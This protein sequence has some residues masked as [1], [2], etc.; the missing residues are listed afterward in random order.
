MPWRRDACPPDD[1]GG[2]P[3]FEAML[4]VA[5]DPDDPEYQEIMEWLGD[6][7]KSAFTVER[8]NRDIRKAI[9]AYTT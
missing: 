3:G 7:K 1:S 2:P 5:A 4:A 9:K 6:W 8:A